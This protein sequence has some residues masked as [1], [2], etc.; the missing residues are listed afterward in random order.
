MSYP[1]MLWH[2]K[3]NAHDCS[4]ILF[5]I[6]SMTHNAAHSGMEYQQDIKH[7]PCL[8]IQISIKKGAGKMIKGWK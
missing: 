6:I 1:M 7:L 4:A 5:P 8:Y 2:Q 3:L